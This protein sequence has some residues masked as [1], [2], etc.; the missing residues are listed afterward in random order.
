MKISLNCKYSVSMIVAAGLNDFEF[1]F[2]NNVFFKFEYFFD[3]HYK[4]IIFY[5]QNIVLR[6]KISINLLGLASPPPHTHCHRHLQQ[7]T[8]Q[9]TYLQSAVMFR[10]KIF[11][12][13]I[14]LALKQPK[15]ESSWPNI[16]TFAFCGL[17]ILMMKIKLIRI[18]SDNLCAYVH[19]SSLS[20]F[21]ANEWVSLCSE[22]E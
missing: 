8:L 17:N 11:C 2:K 21:L 15:I 19:I 16:W 5:F 3:F 7:H 20:L 14:L 6:S 18:A 4:F 1:F 22:I 9:H 12:L 10:W 13:S